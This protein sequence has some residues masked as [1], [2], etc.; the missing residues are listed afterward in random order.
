MPENRLSYL[1]KQHFLHRITLP[2]KEEMAALI[3]QLDDEAVGHQ[4]QQ[5]WN[6][7]TPARLLGESATERIIAEVLQHK[8]QAAVP[9]HTMRPHRRRWLLWAAAAAVIGVLVLSILVLWP[10]GRQQPVATKAVILADQSKNYIQNITLPDGSTVVLQ[11]GSTLNY[12]AAFAGNTREV[13]LT[14]E[15]YFDIEQDKVRPFLIHTGKV[16]TTVLGTAFNIK[17]YPQQKNIIV[18]VTKGKVKV[19]DGSRLLGVLT[20]DQQLSYR[21]EQTQVEQQQVDARTLVTDWTKQDMVF[22]ETSFATVAAILKRRYNTI[23]RFENS[24]LMNCSVHATFSGTEKLENVL[25]VL[26]K[27]QDTHYRMEGDTAIVISGKGCN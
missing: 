18:S 14:G 5:V 22:D 3:E 25:S 26:C 6:D 21:F 24:A 7:Y 16:V 1:M 15:A 27:I 2:E 4:L 9:V 11:A 23:I 10:G 12:P 20:P 8:Q 13:T 17:A 19:E